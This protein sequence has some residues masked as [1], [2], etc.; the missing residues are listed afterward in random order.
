MKATE[1]LKEEHEV[2]KVVLNVIEKICQKIKKGE[3]IEVKDLEDIIDFIRTFADKCHHGKEE[4]LLFVEMEK[5]GVPKE[6]GPIEEML[7]EHEKG[8]D[9]VRKLTEAI[10]KNDKKQILD[11]A[12]GYVELLRQHI[13][14]EDNI[15]YMIA[16]M[17]LSEE[18]QKEL[19][20]KFEQVEEKKIGKGLHEKYHHLVEKL[21]RKYL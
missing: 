11:N 16:D 2:I 9:Y 8:R 10:K 6:G 7:E 3:N 15:L 20:E 21:N 19:I 13:D 14:K 12:L 1:V 5:S 17:H 4:D 18:K